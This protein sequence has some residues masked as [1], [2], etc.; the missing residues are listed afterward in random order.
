MRF[1]RCH[2]EVG[3]EQRLRTL[4]HSL[5]DTESDE[6]LYMTAVYEVHLS[7]VFLDEPYDT[8]WL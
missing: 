6:A 8:N 7:K 2:E 3:Y 5:M 1:V 4:V